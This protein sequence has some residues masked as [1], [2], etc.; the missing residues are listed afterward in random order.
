MAAIRIPSALH[1]AIP[2]DL[3][4]SSLVRQMLIEAV[5]DPLVLAS[6]FQSRAEFSA[7]QDDVKRYAIY[8][9]DKE[10]E[11][12]TEVADRFLLSLNQM[13]Q[14]LLEDTLYRAG[15]WPPPELD[16]TALKD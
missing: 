15:I 8:L 16:N 11:E 2:Q 14:I 10:K 1:S 3:T 5:A 6:A 9:P 13:I 7:P 12:A 4:V